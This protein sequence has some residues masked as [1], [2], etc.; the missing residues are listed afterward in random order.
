MTRNYEKNTIKTGKQMKNNRK[1][2]SDSIGT[3]IFFRKS[4]HIP[5]AEYYV[6]RFKIFGS[7]KHSRCHNIDWGC[8]P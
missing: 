7:V 6:S 2:L 5:C 1:Y 3:L 4:Q 8:D